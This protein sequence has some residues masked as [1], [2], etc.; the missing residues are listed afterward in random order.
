MFRMDL[1]RTYEHL[2][3]FMYVRQHLPTFMDVR[4]HLL[5]LDGLL[6]TSVTLLTY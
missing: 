3:T 1:R 5:S 4:Q 2:P 6:T